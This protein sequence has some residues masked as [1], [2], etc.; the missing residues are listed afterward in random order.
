MALFIV[1]IVAT[2][3]YV[4]LARLYRDT[5]RTSLILRD[6]QAEYYA[7]GSLA[8]AMDQLRNDWE[9][10][11]PNQVI[12]A[13]PMQSPV[14]EENGYKITSTI[15]DMQARFNVNNLTTVGAQADFKRLMQLVAPTLPAEKSQAIVLAITDWI[16]PQSS[17]SSLDKYY[18][19]LPQPYRPAHKPMLSV[20]ELRLVKGMTPALFNAL[21]PYLVALP[22]PT[23]LNVQTAPAPL[24]V[25]LGPT[26]VLETGLALVEL[27]SKH[28][29]VSPATFQNL[30]IIKNHPVTSDKFTTT[31]GY[32]LVQTEVA[33]E[34]QKVVLYTLLERAG[35]DKKAVVTILWQ[36]KGIW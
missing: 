6:T 26:L 17:Q 22:P 15:Y 28:P 29:F 11:K 9:L 34:K 20:D 19:E 35:K 14:K 2:M 27:R 24:F 25:T 18:M 4:M 1:A 32:F 23:A 31:S 10:Q 16:S 13:L 30:D 5:Q 21:R 33:I 36:S 7:Q 3:S 8:W 12:D